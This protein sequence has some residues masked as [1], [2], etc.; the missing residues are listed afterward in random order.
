MKHLFYALVLLAFCFT[1]HA[2][3]LYLH[4]IPNGNY[5]SFSKGDKIEIVVL[6]STDS[7]K[8]VITAIN[9]NKIYLNNSSEGVDL[10][11]VA[12]VILSKKSSFKR[13]ALSALGGYI[14]LQ[15]TYLVIGGAIIAAF[16]PLLGVPLVV[17]GAGIGVGGFAIIKKQS[18]TKNQLNI[19]AIDN[20]NNRLFIE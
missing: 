5:K 17:L 18:R 2:Q 15:G 14:I 3:K 10:N 12:T 11:R 8:G 16:E 4:N 19:A 9:E 13:V 1:V 7:T 6:D 20:L